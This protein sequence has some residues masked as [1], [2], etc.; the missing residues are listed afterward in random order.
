NFN[1]QYRGN[2]TSSQNI[3]IP[4]NKYL[5]LYF[6]GP[7]ASSEHQNLKLAGATTSYLRLKT[8]RN[9]QLIDDSIIKIGGTNYSYLQ[10]NVF[11]ET[12]NYKIELFQ[13]PSNVLSDIDYSQHP[14]FSDPLIAENFFPDSLDLQKMY[15]YF[16]DKYPLYSNKC[17]NKI[18]E[19]IINFKI[20]QVSLSPEVENLKENQILLS[21][22][23]IGRGSCTMEANKATFDS[24]L[25][26]QFI[27]MP[28]E[29][30][31]NTCTMVGGNPSWTTKLV[32]L[33]QLDLGF[34][35]DPAID[36]CELKE[37]LDA[38][39]LYERI[40]HQYETYAQNK[41][42]SGASFDD[43]SCSFNG[44]DG[45]I[46][47]PIAYHE[48]NNLNNPQVCLE[49]YNK[50][51][52][53]SCYNPETSCPSMEY[54][55]GVLG[56]PVNGA[57]ASLVDVYYKCVLK[58]IN[59]DYGEA[60]CGISGG[61]IIPY[62]SD[63]KGYSCS[64]ERK[65]SG[66]LARASYPDG[67][68]LSFNRDEEIRFEQLERFEKL[69]VQFDV[70]NYYYQQA[71]PIVKSYYQL[72][73]FDP[74]RD[75]PS[76]V[77]YGPEGCSLEIRNLRSG[78]EVGGHCGGISYL[79]NIFYHL[80]EFK[81]GSV[82]ELSEQEFDE[83]INNMFTNAKPNIGKYP[84]PYSG[85]R[86]LTQINEDEAKEW[87]HV[88]QEFHFL[89]IVQ[90]N[91][92]FLRNYENADKVTVI[93]TLD[94]EY[95]DILST[96]TSNN[97]APLISVYPLKSSISGHAVVALKPEGENCF[98][99]FNSNRDN[100]LESLCYKRNADIPGFILPQEEKYKGIPLEAKISYPPYAID[101][102]TNN[103]GACYCGEA[104][105]DPIS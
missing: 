48:N 26:P 81:G 30:Q 77:N 84:I 102:K 18:Q 69:D 99:V 66:L 89:L 97:Q 79:T 38:M 82:A 36:A 27:A 42:I 28:Y 71:Y 3:T 90:Q 16:P 13:C 46:L 64:E 62:Q 56:G 29:T 100:Q 95:F 94:S 25:Q 22:N 103:C 47:T 32:T 33:T 12:G 17:L 105:C 40:K 104:V 9:N 76:F 101:L 55:D 15:Q 5:H 52:K 1:F 51:R 63:F 92:N 59:K 53:A 58:E 8:S 19:S 24:S 34:T 2:L 73:E 61:G 65:I 4:S 98:K 75:A 91:F 43:F 50:I 57:L 60:M 88:W 41:I 45:G 20:E 87:C 44:Q 7:N 83:I 85:L 93:S 10:Y 35:E 80:A 78:C 67:F 6:A 68:R 72:K 54:T 31:R 23:S 21:P 70:S 37:Q 39:K 86:I 11:N 14:T 49:E 74:A 96:L